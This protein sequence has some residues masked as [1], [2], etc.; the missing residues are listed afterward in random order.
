MKFVASVRRSWNR[1]SCYRQGVRFLPLSMPWFCGPKSISLSHLNI[2][3]QMWILI[4][5]ATTTWLCML[6]YQFE[7]HLLINS[8]C[9][10]LSK[11]LSI[12]VEWVCVCVYMWTPFLI[13]ETI[14]NTINW[15][16]LTQCMSVILVLFFTYQTMWY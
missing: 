15:C 5:T 12:S 2:H 10:I 3:V 11:C 7:A 13:C 6:A 14:K 8:L 4:S 16:R 9:V 1:K